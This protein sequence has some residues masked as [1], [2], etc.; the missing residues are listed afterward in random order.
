MRGGGP[1]AVRPVRAG[2]CGNAFPVGIIAL[3]AL[4]VIAGSGRAYPAAARPRLIFAAVGR[5]RPGGFTVVPGEL[6]ELLAEGLVV[7]PPPV[8]ALLGFLGVSA[9][10]A[11]RA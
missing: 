11:S 4:A 8:T 3:V 7:G 10:A 1:D 6:E 5:I 2:V 9:W